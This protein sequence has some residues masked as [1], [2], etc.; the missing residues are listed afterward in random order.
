MKKKKTIT[1][2]SARRWLKRNATT[3]VKKELD[4]IGTDNSC[5][6][7][8]LTLCRKVVEDAEKE[9]AKC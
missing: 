4:I 5:F 7:R 3:I 1:E 6:H 2:K 9:R 8:Q